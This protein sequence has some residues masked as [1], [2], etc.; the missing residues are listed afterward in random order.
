M[1]APDQYLHV[2]IANQQL[3][4]IKNNALIQTYSISTAK[5]GVGEKMGSECTPRG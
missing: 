4:L 3:S 2:S 5:N 1:N